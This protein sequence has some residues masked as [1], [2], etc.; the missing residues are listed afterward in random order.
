M[1]DQMNISVFFVI[2]F[3][4][5]CVFIIYLITDS[6][7][8]SIH[9]SRARTFNFLAIGDSLTAGYYNYG[10]AFHPYST[11]LGSLLDTINVHALIDEKGVSGELVVPTMANRLANIL[12]TSVNYDWVIILGGTNDLAGTIT[13]E[14]L[15]NEG[16]K[17]MYEMCLNYSK[18]K[19]KLAAMTVIQNAFY[20][21]SHVQD[22]TR[23]QLNNLIRNYVVTSPYQDRIVLVDL[24]RGIPYHSMTSDEE[25]KLVWDDGLH[26]TP[27]GYDRMA[28][29]IFD[30]IK[31]KL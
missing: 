31:N 16:L 15:F 22:Q 19:L 24:D 21:P 4:V 13:A 11:L 8:M 29:L 26:L 10:R 20:A 23:Q 28:V 27:T 9:E 5:L 14:K 12:N 30:T 17:P 18:R 3:S 1:R 6:R 25:R 2:L 7:K